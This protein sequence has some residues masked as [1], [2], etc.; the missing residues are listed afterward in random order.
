MEEMKLENEEED[1]DPNKE[2]EIMLGT[3]ISR[4]KVGHD[5]IKEIHAHKK[6]VE[7]S[8]KSYLTQFMSVFSCGGIDQKYDDEREGC[9]IMTLGV[10]DEC[11]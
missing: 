8:Q 6:S 9:Y 5:D 3:I 1:I 4:V 7:L 11:R 10:I 2:V